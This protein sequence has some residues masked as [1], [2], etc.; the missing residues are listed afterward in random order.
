MDVIVIVPIIIVGSSK[1][2]DMFLDTLSIVLGL[3]TLFFKIT[4]LKKNI[5]WSSKSIVESSKYRIPMAHDTF[6]LKINQFL[7]LRLEK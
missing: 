6:T 2:I 1:I 3:K 7:I 5:E 4:G